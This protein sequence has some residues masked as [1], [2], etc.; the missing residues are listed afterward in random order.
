MQKGQIVQMSI[1][2]FTLHVR[3][4]K[5]YVECGFIVQEAGS[6]ETHAECHRKYIQHM[7]D[8]KGKL[9]LQKHLLQLPRIEQAL[10]SW[11]D[12]GDI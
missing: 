2:R 9:I 4:L 8:S 3:V 10:C 5:L 7:L 6:H 1:L 12:V 11:L